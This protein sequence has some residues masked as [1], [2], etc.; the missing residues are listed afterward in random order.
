[1]HDYFEIL[2]V[3][4]DAR[5]REIQLACRRR[6]PVA[7]PD[8]CVEPDPAASRIFRDTPS[9]RDHTDA[10]LVDVAVDFVDM[11]AVVTRMQMAFFGTSR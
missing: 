7:H 1:M 9:D 11:T 4:P 6:A 5:A 3:S 8:F 10:E 2:G